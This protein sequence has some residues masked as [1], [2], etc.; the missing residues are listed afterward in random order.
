[1]SW[2]YFCE[3]AKLGR[4]FANVDIN[5]CKDLSQ[6]I[7]DAVIQWC[8]KPISLVLYGQPG[9]GKSTVMFLLIRKAIEK[10]RIHNIRW[11]KS[12]HLDDKMVSEFNK[13][14][15][16]EHCVAQFS[17]PTI[18]FLDD[19]GIERSSDRTER[20]YY[21]VIDQRWA[22]LKPTVITTNL[23]PEE[24]EKTYGPRIYSRLKDSKWVHF[25]G[26]DLRGV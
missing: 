13:Y 11:I 19:L 2:E 1:M 20:D 10:F 3:H 22:D 26:P 15:D 16:T 6:E 21:D 23:S 12:K 5:Q 25:D 14:G 24:V 9:R 8:N 7:I 4:R 18:L 17:E